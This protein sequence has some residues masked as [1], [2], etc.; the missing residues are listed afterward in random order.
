MTK[1]LAAVVALLLAP[2][3]LVAPA[4]AVDGVPVP[5][6]CE[7]TVQEWRERALTA[8]AEATRWQRAYIDT[9]IELRLVQQRSG[10]V[11]A[12]LNRVI[13]ELNANIATGNAE[14]D[15]VWARAERRKERLER[16][17]ATIKRLRAKIR[18]LR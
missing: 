12:R 13:D 15:K 9:A 6:E 8:E 16:K 17:A 3:L 18:R 7:E 10:E 1:I 2:L 4:Q 14:F 11:G 5:P